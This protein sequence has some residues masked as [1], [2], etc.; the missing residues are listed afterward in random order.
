M[1]EYV[2]DFQYV[3]PKFPV[4]MVGNKD[5]ARVPERQVSERLAERTYAA[6]GRSSEVTPLGYFRM[7]V[8]DGDG[9]KGPFETL[10]KHLLQAEATIAE[11]E[12]K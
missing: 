11:Y 12:R 9:V 8:K 5:E 4:V 10:A 7:S 6:F 3:R 1:S 2:K